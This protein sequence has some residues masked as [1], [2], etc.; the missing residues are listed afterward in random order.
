MAS[1]SGGGGVSSKLPKAKG[2]SPL[3]METGA[4]REENVGKLNSGSG[5]A[6]TGTG[7]GGGGTTRGGGGGGAAAAGSGAPRTTPARASADL[8]MEISGSGGTKG[9]FK[10]PSAPT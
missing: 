5:S 10:T 3:V 9:F 2:C 6:A 4:G 1:S 8:T 7:G